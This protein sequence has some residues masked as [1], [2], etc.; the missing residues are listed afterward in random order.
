VTKLCDCGCGQPTPI[1][2]RNDKRYGWIKGQPIH[3]RKGHH[4]KVSLAVRFWAQVNKNGP[5]HPVLKTRC[6][7]WTGTRTGP[8]RYGRMYVDGVHTTAHRV[9]WFLETGEWPNPQALHKCDNPACVRFSHLFEGTG[10]DN[11]ADR[12]RKKRQAKGSAVTRAKLTAVQV[13][14]IRQMYGIGVTQRELGSTFGV[15]Q[16]TISAIVRRETWK[17]LPSS[18]SVE[19]S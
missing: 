12:Q 5:V 18:H 4:P 8:M 10:L 15:E 14:S 6:W 17:H 16:G 1:A 7:L 19:G 2:K 13:Q 3:F 11:I 9:A